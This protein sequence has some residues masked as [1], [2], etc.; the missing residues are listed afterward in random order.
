MSVLLKEYKQQL[1]QKWRYSAIFGVI[2]HGI[3]I[4]VVKNRYLVLAIISKEELD[5]LFEELFACVV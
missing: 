3:R 1:R 4:G 2:E 5:I